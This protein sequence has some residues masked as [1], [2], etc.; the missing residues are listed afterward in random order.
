LRRPIC[1]GVRATLT[2]RT[3]AISLEHILLLLRNF[4]DRGVPQ[5]LG[6][7]SEDGVKNG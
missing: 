3:L 4:A 1:S 2:L 5:E 7:G 6:G